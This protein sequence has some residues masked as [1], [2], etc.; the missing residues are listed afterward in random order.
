[1]GRSGSGKSTLLQTIAK[2]MSKREPLLLINTRSDEIL[3]Y[4]K[5]HKKVIPLPFIKLAK[6]IPNSTIFIEDIV[7]MTGTEEKLFRHCLNYD[8]HHKSL[9]LFAVT[10]TIHKTKIFS[11]LPLFH[12]LIFTCTISNLPVFRYVLEFFKID[13]PIMSK[14][15]LH[16]K[17][18]TK[19]SNLGHYFVIDCSSVKLY[20]SSNFLTSSKFLIDS[21]GQENSDFTLKIA[22][23]E[24]LK[25]FEKFI[26]GHFLKASARSIFSII[27]QTNIPINSTDFTIKFI[28]KAKKIIKVS[29]IDYIFTLLDDGHSIPSLDLKV[30][31]NYL[32]KNKMCMFPKIFVKNKNFS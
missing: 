12:Y 17:D 1:L 25:S 3:Q 15:I 29:L 32:I 4:F 21:E 27:S 8:A 14:W 28:T 23:E 10:H 30:L 24:L 9:K 11:T 31:H 20:F 2:Q 16:F 19:T 22:N 7:Y 18:N 6:P 13:K 26:E 5:I